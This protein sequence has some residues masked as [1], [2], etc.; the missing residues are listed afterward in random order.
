MILFSTKFPVSSDFTHDVFLKMLRGYV[1]K[2]QDYHLSPVFDDKEQAEYVFEDCNGEQLVVYRTKRYVAVQLSRVDGDKLCVST[3]VL[4]EIQGVS[5]LFIRL[6]EMSHQISG[7][8]SF[9]L[10]IPSLLRDIFWQEYGGNDN[11]LF[12]DDKPVLLRKSDMKLVQSIFVENNEFLNPVLYVG[13][14]ETTGKPLLDADYL[15]ESLLGVAHVILPKNPYVMDLMRTELGRRKSD[16]AIAL[17]DKNE[18]MLILPSGDVHTFDCD[19][20]SSDDIIKVLSDIVVNVLVEDE[21]SF[22]KLKLSYLLSTHAE[23]SDLNVIYEELLNEKDSTIQSLRDDLEV[24]NQQ[25][26]SLKSKS[27]ALMY[28]LERSK[29]DQV[30]S[31]I[32][33]FVSEQPLYENEIEDVILR[34]LKKE[35]DAMTGDKNLVKSRKYHLLKNIMER[36]QLTGISDEIRAVFDEHMKEGT[37]SRDGMTAVERLDFAV[38]KTGGG[39]Y[40]IVYHNDSRYQMAIS[41]SPSDVR[42]GDNLVTAYMNLLFGY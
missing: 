33:L 3:Y 11:G 36:N 12:V 19:V 15:A 20:F 29:D 4:N 23:D 5:V 41:S 42:A 28:S 26:Y 39:H 31:N 22:S 37:L 32:G 17:C 24:A 10:E 40:K 30:E 38:S 27:E 7:H 1:L 35:Y 34:V 14:D 13:L 18:V 16:N 25:L 8:I 2:S 9:S 6:E 21:L